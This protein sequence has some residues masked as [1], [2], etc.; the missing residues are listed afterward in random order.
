MK[1]LVVSCKTADQVFADFKRAARKTSRGRSRSEPEFEV[2]FDNKANFDRFVRNI[3]VLAAIIAFKPGSIYELAKRLGTDV[4]NL[5]KTI[6]FFEEIG[7]VRI[8]T[9]RVSGRVVSRPQVEFDEVTFRL[10]A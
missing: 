2:S 3:P 6:R 10:A 4:S 1:Q 5:N 9:S 8:K 7:V